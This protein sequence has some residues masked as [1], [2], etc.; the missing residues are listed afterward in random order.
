MANGPWPWPWQQQLVEIGA[1]SK[2][3]GRRLA[4]GQFGQMGPG[5]EALVAS[6]AKWGVDE[7]AGQYLIENRGAAVGVKVRKKKNKE[8]TSEA[9][10]RTKNKNKRAAEKNRERRW[11]GLHTQL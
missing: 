8:K 5:L 1:P 2:Q 6:A 4:F 7:M 11:W 9:N 3:A 10:C